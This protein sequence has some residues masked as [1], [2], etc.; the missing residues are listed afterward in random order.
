MTRASSSQ[1]SAEKE[2]KSF[3]LQG[4]KRC[5]KASR[6]VQCLYLDLPTPCVEVPSL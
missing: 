3:D 1:R 2:V 5:Q 4:I 6:D